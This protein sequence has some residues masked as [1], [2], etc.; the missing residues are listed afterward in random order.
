LPASFA[1]RSSGSKSHGIILE[2]GGPMR[3]DVE[4]LPYTCIWKTPHVWG[5]TKSSWFDSCVFCI[6]HQEWPPWINEVES[7]WLI[8]CRRNHEPMK[9]WRGP[10]QW[11][12]HEGKL[13]ITNMTQFDT[14]GNKNE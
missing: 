6:A 2:K 5:Y 4:I 8:E 7:F 3:E 1:K 10:F 13:L 9:A 11:T 14:S 12:C